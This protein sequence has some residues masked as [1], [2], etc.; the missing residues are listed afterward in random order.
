MAKNTIRDEK[1]RQFIFYIF[2]IKPYQ[3]YLSILLFSLVVSISYW[4]PSNIRL[5]GNIRSELPSLIF[6]YNNWW[7]LNQG[8]SYFD[9]Y[10]CFFLNILSLVE[11]Q[12]LFD[13]AI[14]F[15]V[16]KRVRRKQVFLLNLYIDFCFYSF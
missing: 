8:V 12:F 1:N 11:L 7:Q 15:I 4:D 13:L 5:I 9:S 16:I 14:L 10:L 3:T 2:T 6:G